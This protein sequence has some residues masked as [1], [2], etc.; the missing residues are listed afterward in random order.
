MLDTSVCALADGTIDKLCWNRDAGYIN[1]SLDIENAAED[2]NSC[3][4]TADRIDRINYSPVTT[5]FDIF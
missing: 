3:N 5:R 2:G 4:I 1:F